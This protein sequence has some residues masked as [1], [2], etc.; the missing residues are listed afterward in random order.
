MKLFPAATRRSGF[1][2][3]E[4]AVCLA[5]IGFALVAV[6]GVLPAG[7]NIQRDTRERTVV[8]QDANY[9]FEAIRRGA[10]GT[11]D[12]VNYVQ[13]VWTVRS[14]QGNVV[15]EEVAPKDRNTD[16]KV[17]SLLTR[18]RSIADTNYL[19]TVAL[20]RSLSGP[21]SEKG[22]RNADNRVAFEYFVRSEVVPIQSASNASFTG[23]EID[24]LDFREVAQ[25]DQQY[26]KLGGNLY[27]LRLSVLWPAVPPVYR[28]DFTAKNQVDLRT[29]V[30]GTLITNSFSRLQFQPRR[31]L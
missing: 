11:N 15:V 3:L 20:V 17:V 27:E 2:L 1:T 19:Y 10:Q 24:S 21:A 4:I 25:R 8:L 18:Q 23:T 16:P 28:A 6:L 29:Y 14:E 13:T 5:I 26:F 31:F 22:G 30:S 7:L 9:L 12:L